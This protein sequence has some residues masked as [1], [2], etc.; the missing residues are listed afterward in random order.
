VAKKLKFVV[1]IALALLGFMYYFG[2]ERC[3]D[4]SEYNYSPYC[5]R[6][7]LESAN[8]GDGGAM[9][10]LSLY[11]EG[12]DFEESNRWL[13]SAADK[14]DRRAVLRAMNECGGGKVFS[15]E[16]AEKILL[17]AANEDPKS[18]SIEAMFFYLGGYCGSINVERA[19]TYS[20]GAVDNDL[21]L[22]RV[23]IKYGELVR[24]VASIAVDR[25]IAAEMLQ[26]CVKK[27]NPRGNTYHRAL[28]LLS[29]IRENSSA[30]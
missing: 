3:R 18:M 6:C 4:Q 26:Q 8:A 30:K 27:A 13:H 29:E 19:R 10:N 9:Y 1:F 14:G 7:N 23:A 17:K 25:R 28:T 15:R 5:L 24:S 20:W 16:A 22:C 12:R 11:F 21:Q 2:L